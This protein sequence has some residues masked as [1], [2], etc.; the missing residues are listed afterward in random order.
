MVAE[1]GETGSNGEIPRRANAFRVPGSWKPLQVCLEVHV[2]TNLAVNLQA[3]PLA[4][5]H[6]DAVGCR[7]EVNRCR[8][9][10]APFGL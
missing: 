7:I 6:D 1:L 4:F 10:E 9:T 2:V 8:E 3:I 5:R